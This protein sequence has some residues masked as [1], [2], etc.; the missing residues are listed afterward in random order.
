MTSG[1]YLFLRLKEREALNPRLIVKLE[2]IGGLGVVLP[3]AANRARVGFLESERV[4]RLQSGC[5]DLP[6]PKARGYGGLER[7]C[8]NGNE[9]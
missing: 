7:W 1:F 9:G 2:D 8:R 4:C 3:T 6:E 5:L